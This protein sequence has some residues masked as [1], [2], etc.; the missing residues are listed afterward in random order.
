MSN[1]PVPRAAANSVQAGAVQKNEAK[2]VYA[3]AR[4]KINQLVDAT[5]I[6]FSGRI[7]CIN[8]KGNN[9]PLHLDA[10]GNPIDSR[11]TKISEDTLLISAQL[12][13]VE[14]KRNLVLSTP[15]TIL[16]GSY[17]P[18]LSITLTDRGGEEIIITHS[19]YQAAD[20]LFY[21]EL[22]EVA[23]FNRHGEFQRFFQENSYQ[24][25]ENGSRGTDQ[26]S[27]MHDGAY[28]LFR[29]REDQVEQDS[30]AQG[31]PA[32]GIFFVLSP[33]VLQTIKMAARALHFDLMRLPAVS[34][35]NRTIYQPGRAP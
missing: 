27:L 23:A 26:L 1:E 32:D 11:F 19:T 16:A 31:D 18:E 25:G 30:K 34:E 8:Q 5:N 33:Y 13:N 6:L 17:A 15:T 7:I 2:D 4:H 35:V 22:S 20:S 12:T 28:T 21:G 10:T 14:N 29:Q 9:G 24:Y 3:I